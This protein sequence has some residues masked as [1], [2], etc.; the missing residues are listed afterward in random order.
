MFK[1]IVG[2]CAVV[3]LAQPANAA[4]KENKERRICKTEA[5]TGSHIMTRKV[6]RTAAEWK[7]LAQEMQDVVDEVGRR[8]SYGTVNDRGYRATDQGR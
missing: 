1:A 5:K 8:S 4:E 2:I 3:L 6:C 7:Q